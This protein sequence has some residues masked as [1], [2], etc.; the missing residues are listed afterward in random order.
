MQLDRRN[1]QIYLIAA[2]VGKQRVFKNF[3]E[4][5]FRP[6]GVGKIF[7]VAHC[8]YLYD[9]NGL[10]A[11]KR[12]IA[13]RLGSH[14]LLVVCQHYVPFGIFHLVPNQKRTVLP[15]V[16]GRL[17]PRLRTA[18]NKQTAKQSCHNNK[19]HSFLHFFYLRFLK[20]VP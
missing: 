4:A 13:G 20:Y 5:E 3:I 2:S 14:V 9:V 18:R 12:E 6:I 16:L 7:A 10:P 19:N 17:K 8:L 15:Y 1:A 11:Q